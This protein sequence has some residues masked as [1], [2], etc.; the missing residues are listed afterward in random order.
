MRPFFLLALVCALALLLWWGGVLAWGWPAPAVAGGAIVW[1]AHELVL[2]FAVAGVAGFALTAL[3]EFTGV[4]CGTCRQLRVLVG[5]W[6]LVRLGFWVS[7]WVGLPALALAGAS[8]LALLLGVAWVL[9]PALKTATGRRHW[10]FAWLVLALAVT[11]AGFY[12]DALRGLPG[13]R[14]IDATVGVLMLLIVVA[15]S[16]I[17]MR[18]VNNAIEEIT[19]GADPYL[20]R[21]PRRTLA[22]L[23][24]GF[25]T[26][27]EF[28]APWQPVT[29]WLGLA[30][31]AAML[32]LLNDWHVGRPLWK[33]RFPALLYAMYW[34]M[35]LGYGALGAAQLG[36]L[37]GGSS[38]GRHFLT[39]GAIGL[40]IF[41]VLSIAGRAHVGRPSDP[42]PWLG[43]GGA[44]LLAA[45]VWRAGAA[46]LGSGGLGLAVAAVLW[47]IAFALLAWRVGPGLWLARTDGKQGC[48]D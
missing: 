39:M 19:P 45:T 44:V 33:K 9:L 18:I 24:I 10:A 2:G 21:P 34:C 6:L 4:A 42:G 31:A 46:V 37:A 16:R 3:P 25:Y 15:A 30:A 13:L 43:L 35:A 32:N 20:A 26:V 14:W 28:I 23:C 36:W 41:I 17:S 1:H 48:A 12:G 5:L 8:Q 47:C 27:A 11:S 38:A 22:A 40:G 7:G 29:G